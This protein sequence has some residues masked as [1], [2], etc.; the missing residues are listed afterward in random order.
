VYFAGPTIAIAKIRDYSQS[1]ERIKSEETE[2][3]KEQRQVGREGE[4]M[5]SVKN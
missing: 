4:G 5:S 1:R 3:E 2:G